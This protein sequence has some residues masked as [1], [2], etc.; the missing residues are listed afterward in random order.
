MNKHIAGHG[1]VHLQSQ[2]SEPRGLGVQGQLGIHTQTL[3]QNKQTNKNRLIIE[4][5]LILTLIHCKDKI[6]TRFHITLRHRIVVARSWGE[7][8]CRF[9]V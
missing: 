9:S 3:S 8:E 7:G 6:K 5:L 4:I 1:G 2:H